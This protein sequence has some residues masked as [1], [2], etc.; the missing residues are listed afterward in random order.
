VCKTHPYLQPPSAAALLRA[1]RRATGA[2]A[3]AHAS[4]SLPAGTGA[5]HG[6]PAACPWQEGA[7]KSAPLLLPEVFVLQSA[8]A[9]GGLQ[10]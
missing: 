5:E 10:P 1:A 2:D 9:R 8:G 7:R 6:W 3:A 4:P